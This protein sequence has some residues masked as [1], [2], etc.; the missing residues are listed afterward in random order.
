M[1]V[2]STL[3]KDQASPEMKETF[4]KLAASGESAEHLRGHGAPARGAAHVSP[5]V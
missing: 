4:E 1:P 2:V 3:T 5:F